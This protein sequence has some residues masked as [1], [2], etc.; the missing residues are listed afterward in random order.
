MNDTIAKGLEG[1][2]RAAADSKGFTG[3]ENAGG[4]AND[5]IGLAVKVLPKFLENLQA[6]EDL[7]ELETEGV[8]DLR[9]EVRLLRRQLRELVKSQKA[10][11]EELSL[12][13]E[14]QSTMVT[15]LARVQILEMPDEQEFGDEYEYVDDRVT[16]AQR[17]PS[18]P[19]SSARPKPNGRRNPRP[20]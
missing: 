12:M 13:R 7:V 11:I 10:V 2:L 4:S 8:S 17:R 5:L 3:V 14:L 6:R 20:R 19:P 9:Q 16:H 18:A 1:A 15:H